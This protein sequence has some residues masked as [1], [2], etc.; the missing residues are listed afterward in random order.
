LF[1]HRCDG[2]SISGV[3]GY[4]WAQNVFL[5]S[6]S[7]ESF[8]HLFQTLTFTALVFGF[9]SMRMENRGGNYDLVPMVTMGWRHMKR[10]VKGLNFVS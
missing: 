9:V 5:D 8:A 4:W 10:T 7:G 6:E 3:A 2:L 1:G